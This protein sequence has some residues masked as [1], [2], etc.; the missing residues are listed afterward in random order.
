MY[1]A[2]KDVDSNNRMQKHRV[3]ISDGTHN[4]ERTIDANDPLMQ[5]RI[6]TSQIAIFNSTKYDIVARAHGFG[7]MDVNSIKQDYTLETGAINI[8][9]GEIGHLNKPTYS[10][11]FARSTLYTLY[12]S[13][14]IVRLKYGDINSEGFFP[15][16]FESLQKK[17]IVNSFEPAQG[18]FELKIKQV[19][20]S[21]DENE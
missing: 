13:A 3:T 12:A 18:R 11:G 17:F 5:E 6:R 2:S 8:G 16:P 9:P 14:L 15:S 10:V 7:V 20:N 1:E 19:G 4:F 21:K